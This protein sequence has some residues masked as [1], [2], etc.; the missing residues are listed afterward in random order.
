MIPTRQQSDASFICITG[1]GS[2]QPKTIL[3][4]S[5]SSLP[6]WMTEG[7]VAET[8]RLL[9]YHHFNNVFDALA[10]KLMLES[11]C[12][13]SLNCVISRKNP[14]WEDLRESLQEELPIL[15]YDESE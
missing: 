15:A 5:D 13:A 2:L 6:K 10:H 9:Y 3:F 7:P 8:V 14:G 4:Y 1:S 12:D 11:L